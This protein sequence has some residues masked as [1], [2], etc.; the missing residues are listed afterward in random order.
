[1][2]RAVPLEPA[3]PDV[4]RCWCARKGCTEPATW[5]VTISAPKRGPQ[6]SRVW[7]TTALDLCDGHKGELEGRNLGR[8]TKVRRVW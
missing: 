3:L 5:H 1:M 2:I 8:D 7:G 4:F 6:G